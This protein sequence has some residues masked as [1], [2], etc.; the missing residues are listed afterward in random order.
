M[1]VLPFNIVLFLSFLFGT[2]GAGFCLSRV[3]AAGVATAGV[4]RTGDRIGLPDD[5]TVGFLAQRDLNLPLTQVSF[6]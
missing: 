3:A 2:G 6:N 5:V 4:Q 1:I